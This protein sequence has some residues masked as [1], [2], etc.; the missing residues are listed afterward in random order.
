MRKR[1]RSIWDDE[2]SMK[3]KG[4]TSPPETD[5]PPDLFEVDEPRVE[6]EFLDDA[7]E[8]LSKLFNKTNKRAKQLR[9]VR[10]KDA[11]Q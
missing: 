9:G 10:R 11:W 8:A 5:L 2:E 1:R 6:V 7:H 3:F 4:G